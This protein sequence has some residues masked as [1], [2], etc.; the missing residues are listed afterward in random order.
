MNMDNEY[1]SNSIKTMPFIIF[2]NC[3]DQ[4]ALSVTS[5]GT[6]TF[7][8]KQLLLMI[9]IW[10]STMTISKFVVYANVSFWF[11]VSWADRDT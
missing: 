6:V 4:I 7:V 5:N 10:L 9:H 11:L 3:I 2:L 1:I 8:S